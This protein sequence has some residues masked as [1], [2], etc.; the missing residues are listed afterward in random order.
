MAGRNKWSHQG[1]GPLVAFALNSFIVI[2]RL[3]F[4]KIWQDKICLLT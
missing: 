2:G 4:V 3:F 1:S